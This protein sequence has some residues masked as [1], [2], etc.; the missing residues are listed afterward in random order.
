MEAKE[1]LATPDLLVPRV[2]PDQEDWQEEMD[3]RECPVM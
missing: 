1:Q 2:I 3:R